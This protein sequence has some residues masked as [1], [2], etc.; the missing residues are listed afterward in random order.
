MVY[1]I[2]VMNSQNHSIL[3]SVG[4][5]HEIA[6]CCQQGNKDDEQNNHQDSILAII[7]LLPP[8]SI[9]LQNFRHLQAKGT[10]YRP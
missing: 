6:P 1:M 7:H 5:E 2:P 3:M 4:Y 10:F 9:R 8:R